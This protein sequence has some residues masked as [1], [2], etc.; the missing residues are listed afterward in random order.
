MP[1]TYEA[2]MDTSTLKALKEW[3]W[4]PIVRPSVPQMHLAS[5][6]HSRKHTLREFQTQAVS[7]VSQV[8]GAT[9]LHW[10]A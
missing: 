1:S 10:L 7:S 4:L 9:V 6:L 3:E 8:S 2:V 5:D